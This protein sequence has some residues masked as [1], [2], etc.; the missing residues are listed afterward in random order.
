MADAHHKDETRRYLVSVREGPSFEVLEM[1]VHVVL[2][3]SF[4]CQCRGVSDSG[5]STI[6]DGISFIKP[7]EDK[8]AS[9]PLFLY[10]V[11]AIEL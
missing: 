3:E 1:Y 9:E 2:R 8:L 11:K 4:S 5:V 6:S 10:H 7:L